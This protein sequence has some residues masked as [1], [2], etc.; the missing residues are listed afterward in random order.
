[1]LSGLRRI[2][3]SFLRPRKKVDVV[4]AYY[5]ETRQLKQYISF[6]NEFPNVTLYLYDKKNDPSVST[7]LARARFETKIIP[8]RNTG[9]AIHTYLHHLT[10]NYESLSDI[11]LFCLGSGFRGRSKL[12]KSVWL[13]KNYWRCQG[14]S[15][16]N[17]FVS[18]DSDINF[19]LPVYESAYWGPVEQVRAE[20]FPLD[21]WISAHTGHGS[22]SKPLKKFL[23]TN[24]D[25]FAVTREVAQL[26]SKEF[27]VKLLAQF[28]PDGEGYNLEAI[29]FLER[30]W[31]LAFFPP[32][33]KND[34]KS[35]ELVPY[36]PYCPKSVLDWNKK[37]QGW[38]IPIH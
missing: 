36:P 8:L 23:R 35:Q 3:R 9:G 33:M 26:R 10:S 5:G 21:D 15:S 37:R 38:K 27:W 24:K 32:S 12:R 18:I 1:M 14:F 34:C 20:P 19:E 6:L 25:T 2:L 4:I 22:D 28:T 29:H 13:L 11:T 30:A 16:E 17:I 31:I 7:I